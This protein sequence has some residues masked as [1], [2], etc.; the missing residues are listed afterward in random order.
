[1]V[2]YIIGLVGAQLEGARDVDGVEFSIVKCRIVFMCC[3]VTAIEF[4][5]DRTYLL[6]RD[7]AECRKA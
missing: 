2:D 5:L 4:P 1:M 6:Q 7:V 3:E